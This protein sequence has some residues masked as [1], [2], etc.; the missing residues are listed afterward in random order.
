MGLMVE[1]RFGGDEG[2]AGGVI[3]PGV[4]WLEAAGDAPGDE[5]RGESAA[6]GK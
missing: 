6:D 2:R 3:T 5:M 1:V 4:G